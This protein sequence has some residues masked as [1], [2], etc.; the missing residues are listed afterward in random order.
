[1]G[2]SDGKTTNSKMQYSIPSDAASVDTDNDGFVDTAYIGDLGGNM[3]RFKFCKA[4]DAASTA[5]CA[6][7]D[8][9]GGRLFDGTSITPVRPIYVSPAVTRDV[10]GNLWVYW[11]TGDKNDPMKIPASPVYSEKLFA[12]KDAN[13]TTAYTLSNLK[14]ITSSSFC[15]EIRAGCTANQIDSQ[16]GYY[17]NLTAGGGGEKML[18]EPLI[19]G[20]VIYFTTFTPPGTSVTDCTQEGSALLYGINYTSGAGV[21]ASGARSI[22]IGS[23]I[24]SAPVISMRP[25]GSS[26]ADL[27]VTVSSGFIGCVGPD[28]KN[29]GRAPFDPPGLL[30]RTNVLFW[31]DRRL[32]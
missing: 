7:S 32:E 26:T 5:G 20:G 24:P 3:W 28:C 8:W 11:G 30:N 13:S 15:N 19:F 21:F 9:S 2:S 29:T 14:D 1:M 22:S 27:Y 16:N 17:I 10:A 4:A 23:G 31:K 6:I 25:G 12:V 18:A